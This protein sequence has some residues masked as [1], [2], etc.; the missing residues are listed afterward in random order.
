[1]G[2]QERPREKL[3]DKE[4]DQDYRFEMS[5]TTTAKVFGRAGHRRPNDP[6]ATGKR[7]ACTD[8]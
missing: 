6:D 4:L 3:H 7:P 8:A 1:M 2:Q 5:T